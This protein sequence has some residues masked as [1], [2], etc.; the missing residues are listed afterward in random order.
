MSNEVA[1]LSP[2]QRSRAS[3]PAP[4]TIK[5]T[6]PTTARLVSVACGR[7]L[8]RSVARSMYLSKLRGSAARI[9][10]RDVQI[11]PATY[12]V[13]QEASF[14][15]RPRSERLPLTTAPPTLHRTIFHLR[16]GHSP[17]LERRTREM[18]RCNFDGFVNGAPHEGLAR[19]Y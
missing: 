19:V 3:I 17:A 13:H 8:T 4:S 15:R 12:Q 2:P 6:G 16:P 1:T 5:V 14:N 11:E 7:V 10:G 18:H 9:R